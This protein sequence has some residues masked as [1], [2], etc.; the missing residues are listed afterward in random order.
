MMIGTLAWLGMGLPADGLGLLVLESIPI[1]LV[2]GMT[3]GRLAEWTGLGGHLAIL[4]LLCGFFVWFL[5]VMLLF[6]G[7]VAVAVLVG[8]IVGIPSGFTTG[9]VLW[10]A[11][12]QTRRSAPS[13]HA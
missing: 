12:A 1:S 7:D 9:L 8:A 10:L 11:P 5:S 4:G 2:L 6:I 13:E 3:V